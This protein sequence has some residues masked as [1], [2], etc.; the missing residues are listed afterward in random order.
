MHAQNTDGASV[1]FIS[2]IKNREF[3]IIVYKT[4]FNFIRWHIEI[5]K[6]TWRTANFFINDSTDKMCLES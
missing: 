4:F 2:A 6:I 5:E 1:Y 3:N